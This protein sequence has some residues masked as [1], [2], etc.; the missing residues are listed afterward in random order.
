VS[1]GKPLRSQA[2]FGRADKDG[3]IHRGLPALMKEIADLLE[4]DA[5][6]AN[7]KTLDDNIADAEVFDREVIR[8]RDNPIAAQGGLADFERRA[9]DHNVSAAE[10]ER[11]RANW[12]ALEHSMQGGY[13]S[14]YVERV[15]QAD[16]GA[17]LDF[18]VGRRGA[19]VPRES[20]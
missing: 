11:R 19:G 18:L 16:R 20:H 1:G 13:H 4:L 6:T 14:L 7:G 10:F 15:L 12:R 8:T 17:D 5:L 9:L 3:F 2:W